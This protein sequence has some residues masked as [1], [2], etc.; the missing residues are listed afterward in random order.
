MYGKKSPMRASNIFFNILLNCTDPRNLFNV[1]SKMNGEKRRLSDL[2]AAHSPFKAAFS[3][4][5]NL[6]CAT[7]R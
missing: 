2:R 5:Q 7:P 3:G 1:Q 6:F 4:P